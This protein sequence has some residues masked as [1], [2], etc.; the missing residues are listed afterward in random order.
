MDVSLI[1]LLVLIA[2]LVLAALA[3][4]L[5]RSLLA[6]AILLALASTV[7]SLILFVFGMP[8]AAVMELAVCTGLVT[9]IY[10]SAISLMSP[11]TNPK[12]NKAAENRAWLYRHMALPVILLAL[13]A[14]ILVFVPHLDFG[15]VDTSLA[16][17][18]TQAVLWDLR[19]V[20]IFGFA[21]LVLAGVLGVA[22]L[23]DQR[24]EK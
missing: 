15:L 6:S 8:L 12:R 16:E 3:T 13:T 20:D 19:N 9:A 23:I 14:L 10:A 24:E 21:L 22:V 5:I 4:V 2:L 17:Q 18:N 7:V 11:D 1:I